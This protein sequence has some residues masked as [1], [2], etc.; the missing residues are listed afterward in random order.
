MN[1]YTVNKLFLSFC[2]IMIIAFCFASCTSYKKIT[3][4]TDVPYAVN[5]IPVQVVA[6]GADSFQSIRIE[7][8]DIIQVSIHTLDP[9][10]NTIFNQSSEGIAASGLNSGILV[11]KDG[12]IV[13]PVIGKVRVGGL[14]S[15]EAREVINQ[16]ANIYLKEPIVNIR[17]ANFKITVIGEVNKPS[18][19]IV[20]D[21]KVNVI[22][23]IGLAGDLTVFGKRKNMLLIRHDSSDRKKYIRLDLTSSEFTNSQYFYLKQGDILYVEPIKLKSTLQNPLA[24]NLVLL[25]G[26]ISLTAIITNLVKK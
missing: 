9:Q 8:N 19:I 17:I 6:N 24:R 26:V 3:Y 10:V 23:A 2:G 12:D 25:T 15:A 14:T 5:N 16:K 7:P 13:L 4:L 11:D 22:E 18:Q 21:E 20:P 1:K